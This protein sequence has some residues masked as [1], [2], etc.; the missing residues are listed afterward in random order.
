MYRH[1]IGRALSCRSKCPPALPKAHRFSWRAGSGRGS[2]PAV[3]VGSSY[4]SPLLLYRCADNQSREK[5]LPTCLF[6]FALPKTVDYYDTYSGTSLYGLSRCISVWIL[7]VFSLSA[8]A[9]KLWLLL[10]DFQFAQVIVPYLLWLLG[11]E[12]WADGFKC[13]FY[14]E[15]KTDSTYLVG[16]CCLISYSPW[17][18]FFSNNISL[19][20]LTHSSRLERISLSQIRMTVQP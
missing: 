13:G 2:F 14:Q 15:Q 10:C 4:T 16:K 9:R 20:I 8:R 19:T 6:T 3:S 18:I 12:L 7:K 11:T 1:C 5:L 17:S